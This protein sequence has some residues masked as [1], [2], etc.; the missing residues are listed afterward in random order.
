[1]ID[2]AV[3]AAAGSVEAAAVETAALEGLSRRVV[4]SRFFGGFDGTLFSAPIA[5]TPASGAALGVLTVVS[6]CWA[7]CSG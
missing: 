6:T 4:R 7:G 3:E 2:G 5:E 1:M